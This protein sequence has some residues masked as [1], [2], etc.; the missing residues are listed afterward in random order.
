MM[1]N[2]MGQQHRIGA[3]ATVWMPTTNF[4]NNDLECPCCNK[5]KLD[6]G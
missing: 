3:Y 2:P 5:K 4:I 1:Y 6:Q